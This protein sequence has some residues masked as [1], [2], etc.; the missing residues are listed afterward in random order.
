MRNLPSGRRS[1]LDGA[2]VDRTTSALT[3]PEGVSSPCPPPVNFHHG[4]AGWALTATVT[5][6]ACRHAPAMRACELARKPPT[7]TCA[8]TPNC[9]VC[10]AV[11]R[12]SSRARQ[13]GQAVIRGPGDIYE[14]PQGTIVF[15]MADWST[16]DWP[17]S[18]FR[19]DVPRFT[20]RRRASGLVGTA[21][22]R[23]S[24]GRVA[25]G[26]SLAD[27]LVSITGPCLGLHQAAHMRVLQPGIERTEATAR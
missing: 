18:R 19:D 9:P 23:G 4:P 27:A 25:S 13:K 17:T 20:A 5:C 14:P 26:T 24:G 10:P 15:D 3:V 8:S 21:H 7:R 2:E 12:G 6:A 22:D 16:K 1:R 11:S